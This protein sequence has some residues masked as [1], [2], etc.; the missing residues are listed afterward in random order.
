MEEYNKIGFFKMIFNIILSIL[1]IIQSHF[2][3]IE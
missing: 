3:E 2:G 1:R